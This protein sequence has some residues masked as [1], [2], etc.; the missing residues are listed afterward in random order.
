MVRLP[1][2]GGKV[3]DHPDRSGPRSPPSHP[4]KRRREGAL[5]SDAGGRGPMVD[6]D[7]EASLKER[8]SLPLSRAS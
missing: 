3:L 4:L 6:A 5:Q 7:S 2:S 1:R 8:P